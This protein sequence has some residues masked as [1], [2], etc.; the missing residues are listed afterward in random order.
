MIEKYSNDKD[1]VKAIQD[2]KCPVLVAEHQIKFAVHAMVAYGVTKNGNDQCVK[3]KNSYGQDPSQ[4]GD[5][6]N[7]FGIVKYG[8]NL[9]IMKDI[10]EI[11]LDGTANSDGW[12]IRKPIEAIYIKFG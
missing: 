4:P 2:G 10:L 6:Q 9:E 8:K 1:L 5:F 3:C 12:S 7:H 11:P